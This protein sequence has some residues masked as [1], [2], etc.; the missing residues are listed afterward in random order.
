MDCDPIWR[1]YITFPKASTKRPLSTGA[2]P[3][4]RFWHVTLP[5]LSP[6]IFFNV[7]MGL[8][9]SFTY[10]TPV[11]IVSEGT[12]Q[13][14]G[15]TLL[16]SLQM[17]LSA[18]QDLRMGLTSAVAWVLFVILAAFTTLLFRTSRYWVRF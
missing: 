18:F 16:L 9:Q 7:V 2:G 13:P 6:V 17:F 5:M 11:Y 4:R 15:A 8:I 1:H 12:G 3:I 10:F 14:A